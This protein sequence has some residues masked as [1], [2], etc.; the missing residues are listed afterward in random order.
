MMTSGGDG[1]PTTSEGMTDMDK[2]AKIAELK[3]DSKRVYSAS[4]NTVLCELAD[5]YGVTTRRYEWWKESDRLQATF[6]SKSDTKEIQ[7]TILSAIRT[8]L[9]DLEA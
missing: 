7:G 8:Q 2:A 4:G 6:A 9:R 3:A 5:K 1:P